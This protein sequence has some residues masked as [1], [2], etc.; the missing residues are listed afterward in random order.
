M[1]WYNTDTHAKDGD[2]AQLAGMGHKNFIIRLKAGTVFQSHKGIIPHDEMIGLPWGTQVLSHKGS[3]FYLLQPSFA[4][5]LIET[6]RTTQILYP[7][8]IGFLMV[9]LGVMPGLHVIEAGTGSGALTCAFASIVGSTG[10]VT[11]YE[12]KPDFQ[13]L[14]RK[15][16]ERLDLLDRVELKLRNISEGFDETN[17]DILFL[18]VPDPHNYIEY[19]RKALKPG[20]FFGCILPTTNQVSLVLIELK[21]NDFI[22]LEVCEI[23]LRYYKTEPARLRPVDR[24]VAHTGYLIFARPVIKPIVPFD[25]LRPEEES[26]NDL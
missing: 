13:N 2:L 12:A 25:E 7:K 10:K 22:F 14:A 8:D 5:L 18:D 20:G 16:L 11:S 4:D 24:M 21:R 3:P 1:N 6:P 17:A 19:V 23:M 9:N 15:N 26:E